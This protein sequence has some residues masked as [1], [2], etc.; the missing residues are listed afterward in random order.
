MPPS[1][2]KLPDY[3]IHFEFP[4]EHVGLDYADPLYIGDIYPSKKYMNPKFLFWLVQQNVILILNWHQQNRPEFVISLK[5]S[6]SMKRFN[7][8]IYKWWF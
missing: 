2:D 1:T 5:K 8:D 7:F 6:C 4:F 3:R